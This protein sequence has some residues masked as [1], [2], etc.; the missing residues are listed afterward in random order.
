MVC[1][2][3]CVLSV[4]DQVLFEIYSLVYIHLPSSSVVMKKIQE[5]KANMIIITISY[6]YG[7]FY[8]LCSETIFISFIDKE[9]LVLNNLQHCS[10][11]RNN[12]RIHSS[13]E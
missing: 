10:P 4:V 12:S 5:K 8:L 1:Q 6:H 3:V 9:I 13:Y 7:V 11:S 2:A